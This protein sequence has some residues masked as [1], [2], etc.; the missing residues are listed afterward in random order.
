MK[1][2]I[3]KRVLSCQSMTCVVG[4]SRYEVKFQQAMECGGAYVKLLSV[5]DALHLVSLFSLFYHH[6]DIEH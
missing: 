5:H 4:L 6:C 1:V 3:A 2:C